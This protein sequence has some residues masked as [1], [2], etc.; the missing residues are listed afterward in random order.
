M[1]NQ[2]TLPSGESY[3]EIVVRKMP[4][5]FPDDINPHWNPNQLEWSQI[6][7]GASLAMPFLEP[8]LI[9]TMRTANNEISSAQLQK[10][11]SLYIGQEAQ[12]FQQH[13]KFNEVIIEGGY[14][15]LREIEAEFKADYLDFETNRSLKFNLAYACGFESIALALGHWLVK[16][17]EFLFANSDPRVAS[18]I[19]WHFV[20][21]IEHKNVA[22]DAYQAVYGNYLYRIYGTIFAMRHLMK[23]SRRAYRVLLKRDGLWSSLRS[24]WRL[25]KILLRFFANIIPPMI[26]TCL[27]WHHPSGVKDPKW[28]L[29]WIKTYSRDGE[30]L[31]ALD[32][33][34]LNSN[35]TL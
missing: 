2:H 14:P 23:I 7:N 12:H 13:R 33:K 24:R 27:P 5:E 4:F 28:C 31:A 6:V 35:F 21:E 11:V 32:T 29:D 15:E 26:S 30:N 1:T 9:K 8:Y 3:A 25:Q 20:E 34:N 17:R 18:L 16:D 10:E 22:F 19:L